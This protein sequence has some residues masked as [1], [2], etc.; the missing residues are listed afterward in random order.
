MI[1]FSIVWTNP[2]DVR[3]PVGGAWGRATLSIG[4]T[5]VWGTESEPIEWRWA[6]LVEQL[7]WNWPWLIWEQ[8]YPIGLN[9]VSP[10]DLRNEAERRWVA[11]PS[12]KVEE[13][14]DNLRA[15]ERRHWLHEGLG[16]LYL[17]PL[18]VLREGNFMIL[19][20]QN[21][22]YRWPLRE[23][24]AELESIGDRLVS[25]IVQ[26]RTPQAQELAHQWK[27]RYVTPAS[28]RVEI[29]SGVV[30]EQAQSLA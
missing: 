25:Q 10:L 30:A 12:D 19:V 6:D 26:S 29:E 13:E 14:D 21:D 28:R 18:G 17:P 1:S 4:G 16:A 24:V 20:T 8:A 11:M 2:K 22:V 3:D 7:V 27:E 23:V 15:W 5:S 9:P